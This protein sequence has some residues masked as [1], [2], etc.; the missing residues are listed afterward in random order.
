[1]GQPTWRVISTSLVPERPGCVWTPALDYLTPGRLYRIDVQELPKEPAEGD[2]GD[3]T[4][5]VQTWTPESVADPCT[6]DGAEAEITRKNGSV[7][8]TDVR[9]GALIG[10]VGGSTADHVGQAER[11]MLFGVGRYCV[12][13]A[14]EAAKAGPLYLGVND[15]PGSACHLKGQLQVRISEAL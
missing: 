7:P 3:K 10:R 4:T 15:T 14:P 2:P 5:V 8:L 12:F 11:M 9:I 6:A 13:Q 1:M